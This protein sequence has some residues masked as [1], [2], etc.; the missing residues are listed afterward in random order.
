MACVVQVL[1]WI[2]PCGRPGPV[3]WRACFEPPFFFFLL[4][5]T[6]AGLH[7]STCVVYLSIYLRKVSSFAINN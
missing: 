1:M 5:T 3:E 7:A 4:T 2:L 6:A